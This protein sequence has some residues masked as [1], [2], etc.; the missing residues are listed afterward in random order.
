ME[1]FLIMFFFSF[2]SLSS[3][4]AFGIYFAMHHGVKMFGF[5]QFLTNCFVKHYQKTL[6][7]QVL[8]VDSQHPYL[9]LCV[10]YTTTA[11]SLKTTFPT[12]PCQLVLVS[13]N[14]RQSH[15]I[16]RWKKC[17]SFLLVATVSAGVQTSRLL[18]IPPSL[19]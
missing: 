15:G 17:K 2:L 1:F 14:G 6:V 3:Y 16:G 5:A 4:R 13:A 11:G 8:S 12:G 7:C 19:F 18:V 10:L 9:F